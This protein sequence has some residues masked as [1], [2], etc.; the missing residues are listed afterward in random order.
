[1]NSQWNNY[2][3]LLDEAGGLSDRQSSGIAEAEAAYNAEARKLQND[4]ASAER[5]FKTLKDRNTRLQ[6]SVRDLARSVGVS[7][8][9]A[10]EMPPLA[11]AQISDSLKSAEYDLAQLRKSLEYIKTQKQAV[12]SSPVAPFPEPPSAL[13]TE[14]PSEKV[15]ASCPIVAVFA[16]IGLGIVA[17]IL[18]ALMLL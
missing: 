9:T 1:M 4:L 6:V 7:I 3:A 10:S 13:P 18:V 8:P 16:G 12:A 2:L 11:F 17:L 15:E 5:A 14:R